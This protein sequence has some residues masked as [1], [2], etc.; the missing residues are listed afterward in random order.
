VTIELETVIAWGRA[1][2]DTRHHAIIDIEQDSGWRSTACRTRWSGEAEQCT[3]LATQGRLRVSCCDLIA[4][5]QPID[6]C[7]ACVER[8][9]GVLPVDGPAPLI[10]RVIGVTD[11]AGLAMGVGDCGHHHADQDEAER[12]PWEPHPLPAVYAGLV[13]PVRDT[14]FDRARE[15]ARPWL[16]QR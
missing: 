3:H 9:T 16:R 5:G 2:R 13:R 14:R 7:P 6:V 1:A 15:I 8:I 12:C 11:A 4:A 10:W